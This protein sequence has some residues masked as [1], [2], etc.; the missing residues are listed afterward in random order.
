MG[1]C[2]PMQGTQVRCQV[3][4]DSTCH[5]ATKP[6]CLEPV[7]HNSE[8]KG[9]ATTMRSLVLQGRVAPMQLWAIGLKPVGTPRNQAER[10]LEVATEGWR[11]WGTDAVTL[12]AFGY[13]LPQETLNSSSCTL[14]RKLS[15]DR[16]SRLE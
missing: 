8:K 5:G 16:E 6:V 10:A 14:T 11:G 4:E 2:L 9:K 1:I 3:W 7:F 15:G 12:I 13:S